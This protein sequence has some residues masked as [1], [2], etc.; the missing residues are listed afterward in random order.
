[1][2]VSTYST[3]GLHLPENIE[4]IFFLKKLSYYLNIFILIS[5]VLSLL[6]LLGIPFQTSLMFL[7]LSFTLLFRTSFILIHIF[8][9]LIVILW[10]FLN[11]IC[12]FEN[13]GLLAN[14]SFFLISLSIA[15]P[16]LKIL[17]HRFHPAQFLAFISLIINLSLVLGFIY[18]SL[19]NFPTFLLAVF[20]LF[21]SISILLRW[22]GRG[23]VSYFNIESHISSLVRRTLLL[24]LLIIPLV[25]F[26]GILFSQYISN[27]IVSLVVISVIL[28]WLNIKLLYNS[29][30]ERFLMKEELRVH[31]INLKL[32]NEDLVV[33]MQ[34]LEKTKQNYASQLN[35]QNK[36]RDLA[37]SLG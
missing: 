22:P 30:L 10:S 34:E 11:I 6:G 13:I 19:N 20:F 7:I 8:G 2:A 32:N 35:Y 14:F 36:F 26:I 12:G 33:K 27:I 4:L 3:V 37:E 21:L 31:N 15:I 18:Q 1:V 29:E 17:V 23:F 9:S 16:Y 5:S 28:S 25:G 24:N